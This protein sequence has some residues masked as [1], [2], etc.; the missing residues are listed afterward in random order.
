MTVASNTWQNFWRS[1]GC[2]W[3][4]PVAEQGQGRSSFRAPLASS[5]KRGPYAALALPPPLLS[6]TDDSG[7][8]IQAFPAGASSRETTS[9]FPTAKSTPPQLRSSGRTPGCTN[10]RGFLLE[11]PRMLGRAGPPIAEHVA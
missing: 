10:Q 2:D 5:T 11:G 7:T 4:T 6:A 8:D 1:S 3:L 9:D